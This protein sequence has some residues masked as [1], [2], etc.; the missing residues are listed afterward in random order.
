MIEFNF[1]A[2]VNSNGDNVTNAYGINQTKDMLIIANH[3]YKVEGSSGGGLFPST[4]I[5]D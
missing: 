1:A 5:S 4:P 2:V 3:S